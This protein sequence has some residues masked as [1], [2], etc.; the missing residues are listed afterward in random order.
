MYSTAVQEEKITFES[1]GDMR[2]KKAWRNNYFSLC[3]RLL[4][5]QE[6]G[7]KALNE[8]IMSIRNFTCWERGQKQQKTEGV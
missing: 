8:L 3:V 2:Y 7:S 4:A 6:L 1:N 5:E